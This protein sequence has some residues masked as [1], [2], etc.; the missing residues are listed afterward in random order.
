MAR[1]A[2]TTRKS[3]ASRTDRAYEKIK[4]AIVEN[5]LT[6][7]A[8]L[9]EEKLAAEHGL[10]RTPI[11]EILQALA[12]DGLVEII[13]NRGAFVAQLDLRDVQ[14][15]SEVRMALEGFAAALAAERMA[16]CSLGELDRLFRSL[17]ATRQ[18]PED[19][20]RAGVELH[21]A[22]GQATQNRRLIAALE[23]ALCHSRRLFD[24][25]VGL[26]QRI[27][28]SFDEHLAILDALNRRDADAAEEAMRAHL[29]STQASVVGVLGGPHLRNAG[30]RLSGG[31]V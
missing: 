26:P 30:R 31:G 18:D 2:R 24:F 27:E 23:N 11:R 7:E 14:E 10:S 29:Q 4:K 21:A 22:I 8:C 17:Q 25:C 12:R 13:R 20:N 1:A 16:D 9:S 3:S 6:P 5:R 15:I 28:A 19:L